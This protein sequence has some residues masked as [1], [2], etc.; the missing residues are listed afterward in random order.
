MAGSRLRYVDVL[1]GIAIFSIIFGHLDNWYLI[2]FTFTYH[3]PVFFLITGYFISTKASVGAFA[4]QRAH[5][6]LVPYVVTAL[7]TVLLAGV[8]VLARGQ[9][10][11][12]ALD[13]MGT[14][15]IAALYGAGA[16]AAFPAGVEPIG[17]L[18]FLLACFWACVALR[19]L[20]KA[21]WP[22]Q[23]LVAAVVA[24][25][26]C[27]S[28]QRF[29]LPLSLQPAGIALMYMYLG[30]LWRLAKPKVDRWP[31]G[32]R[33]ALGCVAFLG[34]AVFLVFYNGVYIVTAQFKDGPLDV[35]GTLAACYSVLLIAKGIDR[36]GDASRIG[37]V[38]RVGDV[39]RPGIVSRIG[40]ALAQGLA[41][42]GR[43]SL[44]ML[45]AHAVEN[46]LFRWSVLIGA[47][48]GLGLPLLLAQVLTLLC[49][50]AWIV[51]WTV[52]LSRWSGARRLFGIRG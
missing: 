34:W 24:V 40:N 25:V 42:C 19:L 21:P 49:K 44:F 37:D 10:G 31:R 14:W 50:L 1:R 47:L 46:A 29:F 35:L 26:S 52:L 39:N 18:W 9:G 22:A 32:G 12:A 3:V 17:M 30:H 20:L 13:T 28:A 38:G 41:F 6:L 4:K 36:I 23:V 7:V 45:C 16:W 27:V 51:G 11:P 33:I 2:H 43:Y 15:S 5:G 48:T 8:I